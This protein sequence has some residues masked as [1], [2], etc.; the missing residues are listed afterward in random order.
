[1]NHA[2]ELDTDPAG[3]TYIP[4]YNPKVNADP[5][6]FTALGYDTRPFGADAATRADTIDGAGLQKAMASTRDFKGVT[7]T[8]TVDGNHNPVKSIVVIG[9]KDGKQSTSEKVDS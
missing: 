3:E 9:L 4:H 7:G 8:I 2:A 5:N 1:M 6:A